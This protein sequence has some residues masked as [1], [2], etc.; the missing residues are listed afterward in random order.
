MNNSRNI[1]SPRGLSSGAILRS[2]YVIACLELGAGKVVEDFYAFT[3]KQAV[4]RLK[5]QLSLF[6]DGELVLLPFSSLE[7]WR[8]D[9]FGD[10]VIRS[11]RACVDLG[12]QGDDDLAVITGSEVFVDAAA[13]RGHR[14]DLML[15]CNQAGQSAVAYDGV[16][17]AR[18][19]SSESALAQVGREID[20]LIAGAVD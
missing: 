10:P 9:S 20:A 1:S 12:I 11:G 19:Q 15:V 17:W 2:R 6:P 8:G 14:F 5:Q 16:L 4:Y 13:E 7:G 18:D 3:Y